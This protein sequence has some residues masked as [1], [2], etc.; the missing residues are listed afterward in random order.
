MRPESQSEDCKLCFPKFRISPAGTINDVVVLSAKTEGSSLMD[1]QEKT[2]AVKDSDVTNA[3]WGRRER[4][5]LKRGY[6]DIWTEAIC[7]WQQSVDFLVLVHIHY[8]DLASE[9]FEKI[10]NIN[11]EFDLIIT[12]TECLAPD[13]RPLSQMKMARSTITLP[14]PNRGRDLLPMVFVVNAG[15]L[16]GYKTVLKLHTKKSEWRN[17]HPLEGTG[18]EWREK[19]LSELLLDDRASRYV[20]ELVR[21]RD[22]GIVGPK[23]SVLDGQYFVGGNQ[24]QI[25]ALCSRNQIS[26]DIVGTYSFVA[27]SMYYIR[28]FLL[29]G[30]RSF[31]LEI[32]DFEPETGQTDGTMAHAIERFLG[33]AAALSGLTVRSTDQFD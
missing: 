7:D 4:L 1:R 9:L 26:E 5:G 23:G 33:L 3:G 8:L 30:L 13:F 2:G 16:T 19:I 14:V 28:A 29:Q 12:Y 11:Q 24:Q 22:L 25:S 31:D 20:Q 18:T 6:P 15:F 17:R 10:R 27:G 21:S 32:E